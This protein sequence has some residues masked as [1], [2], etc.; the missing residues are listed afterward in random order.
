MPLLDLTE[1]YSGLKAEA[2]A[3]LKAAEAA[4]RE[5]TADEQQRCQALLNAAEEIEHLPA[6]RKTVPD[7]PTA[8]PPDSSWAS[9]AVRRSRSF[10]PAKEYLHP[11]G[12]TT[13]VLSPEHRL[14]DLPGAQKPLRGV[15][16]NELDAGRMIAVAINQNCPGCEPERRAQA[17][18]INTAGGFLVADQFFAQ[19]IDLAR[20]NMVLMNLGAPTILLTSDHAVMP[21]LVTDPTAV[22]HGENLNDIS[23]T[24]AVFSQ[25]TWTPRT[26][27]LMIKFSVELTEDCALSLGEELIKIV[28]AVMA[29]K[30][31]SLGL[32]GDPSGPKGLD[33]WDDV[34]ETA[35][36]GALT[37][38]KLLDAIALVEEK[39][40]TSTGYVMSPA[41]KL[42]L[43]KLLVASEANH[44]AEPPV[45]VAALPRLISKQCTDSTAYL[46]NF[47][48][49]LFGLRQELRIE[50]SPAGDGAFERNQISMRATLRCAWNVGRGNQ[51]VKLTGITT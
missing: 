40:G 18:G 44:F 35:V 43:A 47:A 33:N 45:D 28:A 15:P 7:E 49:V 38:E 24:E 29:I 51:L 36:G 20:N 22:L 16:A 25:M 32:H 30:S 1:T 10:T 50:F 42:V 13:Y 48:E 39:N 5:V 17:E 11:N 27:A 23:D 14:V 46:G 37:Y 6:P 8:E 2:G 34:Q 31:D 4:D 21:K 26:I 12:T 9:G 41:N 19:I 3:I